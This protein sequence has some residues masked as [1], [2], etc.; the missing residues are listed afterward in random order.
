MMIVQSSTGSVILNLRD[1]LFRNIDRLVNQRRQV[2]LDDMMRVRGD[3]YTIGIAP[4]SILKSWRAKCGVL[5][6]Y[7]QQRGI[8]EPS[9]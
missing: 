1:L 8:Q 2:E 9:S 4:L 6:N 7:G 3:E 5:T